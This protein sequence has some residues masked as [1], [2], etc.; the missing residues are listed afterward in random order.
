MV[1]RIV[2]SDIHGRG[3]ELYQLLPVNKLDCPV[4]MLGDYFGYG[5]DFGGVLRW[6]YDARQKLGKDAVLCLAGNWEDMVYTALFSPNK[7][8]KDLA[9]KTIYKRGGK[10]LYSLLNRDKAKRQYVKQF[11][12][13][14]SILTKWKKYYLCHAG[15]A[16][17]SGADI[18]TAS[19]VKFGYLAEKAGD[20]YSSKAREMAQ[21]EALLDEALSEE[22]VLRKI[23]LSCLWNGEF[24]AE[25]MFEPVSPPC[26][27]GH[28]PVQVVY[29]NVH[30]N[31]K[32]SKVVPLVSESDCIDIDFRA[33]SKKGKLGYIR[34]TGDGKRTFA[35]IPIE[36]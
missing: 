4:I 5:E 27:L 33:S 29:E 25:E 8:E 20:F 34:L 36:A 23:R 12:E 9:V 14:L 2:I 6:I 24:F 32:M 7:R 35:A 28:V 21:V 11:I 15:I 26:I 19:H 18:K 13:D 17:L 16:D 30:E 10:D 1:D 22:S 3:K 31:E